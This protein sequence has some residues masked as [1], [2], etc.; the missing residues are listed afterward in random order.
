MI[1]L[2]NKKGTIL[3]IGAFFVLIAVTCILGIN[4]IHKNMDKIIY[5][6]NRADAHMLSV[7][8]LYVEI[9]DKISWINKQ[10]KRI[11]LLAMFIAFVPELT[12]LLA[13]TEK[14]AHGLQEYQ[15]ILLLKLTT[16]APILDNKLR[17]EN[18]LKLPGNYHS[19]KYRRQPTINLGFITIPGLIE[20]HSD[21][22]NTACV[23]HRG[24][25]INSRA[26]VDNSLHNKEKGW[27]APVE[28]KW[29]VL[30][31]NAY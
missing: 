18:D 13:A 30:M 25:I 7:V 31:Q 10:L 27:F 14:F 28:E 11:G 24:L 6:Q 9:L 19:F 5:Y 8:G 23:R 16:Y 3:L 15:D 12:P 20:I 21:I 29:D 1:C 4:N 22:F 2:K 17:I 26:C